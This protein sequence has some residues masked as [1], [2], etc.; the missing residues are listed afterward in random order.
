MPLHKGHLESMLRVYEL[1]G[2]LMPPLLTFYQKP[3]TLED[4]IDYLVGKVLDSLD[5]DHHLYKRW[6]ED[7]SPVRRRR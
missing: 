3:R 1:G 5:I 7:V 6:G 2:I 4:M